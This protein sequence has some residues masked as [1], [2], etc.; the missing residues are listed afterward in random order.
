MSLRK[1]STVLGASS[2]NS[3]KTIGPSVVCIVAVDIALAYPLKAERLP[4]HLASVERVD[5]AVGLG[6]RD[7]QEGEAV[8]HQH[9]TH[10]LTVQTGRGGN[11]ADDVG[12]AQPRGLPP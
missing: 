5:H 8:E 9:I 6:R 1:F 7:R 11:R 4:T 12:N 10:R 3:S 2:S